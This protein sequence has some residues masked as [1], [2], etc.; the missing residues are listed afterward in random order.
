MLEWHRWEVDRAVNAFMA[1]DITPPRGFFHPSGA[2]PD[3]PGAAPMRFEDRSIM[4]GV[5]A[6]GGGRGPGGLPNHRRGDVRSP[7]GMLSVVVGLPFRLLGKVRRLHGFRVRVDVPRTNSAG[8]RPVWDGVVQSLRRVARCPWPSALARRGAGRG[9]RIYPPCEVP[10]SFRC[11]CESSRVMVAGTGLICR[12][13]PLGARGVVQLRSLGVAPRGWFRG[14]WLWEGEERRGFRYRE[15]GERGVRIPRDHVGL[16][17][18]KR[19]PCAQTQVKSFT[20][21]RGSC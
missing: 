6:G 18:S 7:P 15:G 13:E 8:G 3:A 10:A 5:G 2:G 19:S 11:S 9:E 21:D 4:A 16:A 14:V 1:G 20:L 17:A 12:R